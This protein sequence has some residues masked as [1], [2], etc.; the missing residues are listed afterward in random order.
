M[1]SCPLTLLQFCQT[2]P[3]FQT[4]LEEVTLA[5]AQITDHVAKLSH[6]LQELRSECLEAVADLHFRINKLQA[7]ELRNSDRLAAQ[8][9][10][11]EQLCFQLALFASATE[12]TDPLASGA[13][14]DT[15]D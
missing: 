10:V 14:L 1:R 11:Q 9:A 6:A 13:W 12:D 2:L 15:M 8:A 5:Q 3:H 4:R 7:L